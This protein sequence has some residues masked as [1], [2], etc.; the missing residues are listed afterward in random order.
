MDSVQLNKA[1]EALMKHCRAQESTSLTNT[2][3]H[4][5]AQVVFKKVPNKPK[6]PVKLTLKHSAYN[7]DPSICLVTKDPQRYYKDLMKSYNISVARV[8][9]VG[10]LRKKFKEL[11]AKRILCD[12]HDVFLVDDRVLPIIPRWFGNYF[13]RK[14]KAPIKVNLKKKNLKSEIEEATRSYMVANL[15]KGNNLSIP[16]GRVSFD[17]EWLSENLQSALDELCKGVKP[18]WKNIKAVYLKTEDSI[19]LPVYAALNNQSFKIH[20]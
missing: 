15:G 1:V 14:G 10:K 9:G 5:Y 12:N 4:V 2:D 16:C 17:N 6:H 11:E 13:Y 20:E 3:S 19:S 18:G 7:K 8:I